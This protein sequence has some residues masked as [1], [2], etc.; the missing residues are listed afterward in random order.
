M[1]TTQT[2]KTA[3]TIAPLHF[4]LSFLESVICLSISAV[5]SQQ[6]ETIPLYSHQTFFRI[7]QYQ[8]PHLSQP[9]LLDLLRLTL[10]PLPHN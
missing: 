2:S 10:L 9:H 6:T 5:F 1:E 8:N 4:I 3:Y 7:H